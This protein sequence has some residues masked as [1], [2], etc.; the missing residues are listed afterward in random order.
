MQPI[1]TYDQVNSL[2]QGDKLRKQ[3]QDEHTDYEVHQNNK[4]GAVVDL[5]ILPLLVP[6]I[7]IINGKQII[8]DGTIAGNFPIHRMYKDLVDGTWS[9]L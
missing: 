5:L 2:K 6:D 9:A 8:N 7:A 1:T 3:F 4:I